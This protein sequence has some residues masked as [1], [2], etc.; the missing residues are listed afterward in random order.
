MLILGQFCVGIKVLESNIDQNGTETTI[1]SNT[2]TLL[3]FFKINNTDIRI[4]EQ[5]LRRVLDTICR[6][7]NVSKSNQWSCTHLS[8][9]IINLN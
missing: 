7:P 3:V 6:D 8:V 4:I 1:P 2:H 5:C 9:F